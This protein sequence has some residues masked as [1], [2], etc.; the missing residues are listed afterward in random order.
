MIRRSLAIGLVAA[1]LGQTALSTQSRNQDQLTRAGWDA[2]NAGRLQEASA[3][4]AEA[5]GAGP[6]SAPALL[7]AALAAHLQTRYEDARQHLVSALGLEPSLLPASIL[8]G[9][10]L[11]RAGDLDGAVLTYEQALVRAPDHPQIGK[12][13]ETW[14]KEL[15]LHSRFGQRYSDHFTILFEGPA[16]APLAEHAASVL[17]AAYWR[18]G[19]ALGLYPRDVISV[20]LYTREQFRDVTESPEWAGGAFDGRIRVPVQGALESTRELD[21]VL[22]HEFTH[23]LVHSVAPRGVPTWLHEGLA[24]V[25]EGSDLGR[26]TEQVRKAPARLPL[27]RLADSFAGMTSAQASLAYAQS[28]VAANA[29]IEQAGHHALVNLLTDIGSGTSFAAAFTRHVPVPLD[30]FQRRL[31]TGIP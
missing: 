21:R 29:L 20:V 14:R 23:A 2:V 13:L 27:D 3:T 4:F 12:K 28:A 30:E 11:Y 18:I 26:K 5:L 24:V 22:T 19:T 10:V 15:A 8:L 9:E 25:L 17:E 7:G 1:V 16:E 31:W 6:P